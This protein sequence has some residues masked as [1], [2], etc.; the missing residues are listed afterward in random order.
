MAIRYKETKGKRY[1]NATEYRDFSC[2]FVRRRNQP[3]HL[4]SLVPNIP[5]YTN[6]RNSFLYDQKTRRMFK[7]PEKARGM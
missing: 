3:R 7:H 1:N 5:F 6:H 4:Y 2:L